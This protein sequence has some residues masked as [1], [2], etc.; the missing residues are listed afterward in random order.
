MAV[1]IIADNNET[2]NNNRNQTLPGD[3][4]IKPG[5]SKIKQAI[6][7]RNRIRFEERTEQECP[8]NCI[9]TGRVQKCPLEEGGREMT[10]YAGKSGNMI[11]QVKN[12]NMSTQITLYHH[13]NKTYGKFE[14]N[15]T[16]EIK[17]MPDQVK[18][19][20][21][22][23]IRKRLEKWEITLEEDGSYRI[24]MRKRARLFLLIPVR[25]KVSAQVN[26]ETGEIIKIRNP[27]W[28]FLAR[29]VAEEE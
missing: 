6:Q 10:V 27:W 16:K 14:G 9:C 29:D 5:P 19:K 11:V 25:E 15:K 28:G 8:E 12:I 2:G 20:I 13:N 18:E 4:E 3:N 23:R 26:S 17:I 22:N 1:E 7:E 24:Q 21:K